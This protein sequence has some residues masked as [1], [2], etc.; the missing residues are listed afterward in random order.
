MKPTLRRTNETGAPRWVLDYTPT[1]GKRIRRFFKTETEAKAAQS[2]LVIVQRRA[3]ESWLALTTV[4]RA[5]LITGYERLQELNLSLNQLID[6]WQAGRTSTGNGQHKPVS[7]QAAGEQWQTFLRTKGNSTMHVENCG[8][9]IRRFSSGREEVTTDQITTQDLIE[10][11]AKYQGVTYN[12]NRDAARGFFGFCADSHLVAKSPFD[13]KQIPKRKII[14]SGSTVLTVQQVEQALRFCA[15]FTPECLLYVVIGTFTGVRPSEIDSMDWSM[16]DLDRG[17]FHL[18]ASITKPRRTRLVHLHPTAVAWIRYCRS[19]GL[20][21]LGAE[22]AK[23]KQAALVPLRNHLGFAEW[24]VDI[25]RHSFGSYT[26]ERTRDVA[27]TALDMGNS[28]QMI[29]DH[30]F[31]V[32]RPEDCQR[33]WALTPE[34]VLASK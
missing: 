9:W 6:A 19:I 32:V 33:F 27:A 12:G 5:D 15:E 22:F 20:E 24:P 25:M 10:Y 1:D 28:P 13:L 2:E 16:I 23:G 3:G 14:R 31:N 11:L 4:Q 18:P 29:M 26:V 30:Y 34:V 8:R 7:L 17:L 21:K